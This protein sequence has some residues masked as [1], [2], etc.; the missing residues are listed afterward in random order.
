MCIPIRGARWTE[1]ETR[2]QLETFRNTTEKAIFV[3]VGYY[4]YSYNGS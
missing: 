2:A 3:D 4:V 1:L